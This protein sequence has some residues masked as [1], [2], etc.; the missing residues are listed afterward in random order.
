MIRTEKEILQEYQRWLEN[1]S[2]E[3][4]Q[5]LKSLPENEI[6]E[7]FFKDLEFGTGGMRGKI[8]AGTNRM[9]V[10]TVSRATLGFADW[11]LSQYS[12]PSVVIAYDTR[13]MSK[14]FAETAANILSGKKIQVYLFEAPAPT[15]LLSYSVRTLK[16]SGG[17]VITASH[18][19][20]EYNGY[21]VYTHDG[22]QAVPRYANQIITKVNANDFFNDIQKDS[23]LISPVPEDVISSYTAHIINLME[24]LFSAKESLKVVYTP[25]H[26]TGRDYVTKVLEK[27]GHEVIKVEEQFTHDGNFPTVKYPNPEDP[28]AFKLALRYA[29]KEGADLVIATDPDADRMG[30]VCK[31]REG[32]KALTGNQVGVIFTAYLLETLKNKLPEK[33]FIV[34]TIVTTDMAKTIASNYNVETRETLTGFKF[35]GELIEE[36]IIK[37]TGNFI[38]GFEE[39][40]GYLYGMHARDKDAVV[41]SAL[42]VTVAAVLKKRGITLWQYLEELYRQYGYY[43]EKL[44]NFTY[45]GIEGLEKISNIMNSLREKTPSEVAGHRLLKFED[46]L[47]GIKGL[48]KSNVI[49]LTFEEDL[50]LIVRPSGTEPKIKFY[51]MTRGNSKQESTQKLQK[52]TDLVERIVGR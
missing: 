33:P 6:K 15:P 36:S 3:L 25:L 12:D 16:C 31:T 45:E 17:I 23:S 38:F 30:V 21:K 18:N 35:I 46:Y 29:G 2:A 34:K 8:G 27:L 26:G 13:K 50:K 40:Y 4:V 24:E 47:E 32:Y 20:P 49:S 48:P 7:R 10:H 52:L 37:K 1:A 11:L 22:T 28:E 39:S 44:L 14:E 42:V 51:L 41:A 9:N 5:E 19:P 43:D